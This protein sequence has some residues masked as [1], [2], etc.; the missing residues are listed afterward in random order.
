MLKLDK[1]NKKQYI[2]LNDKKNKKSIYKIIHG[3]KNMKIFTEEEII[4]MNNFSYDDRMSILLEY[5][6]MI[7]FLA[8]YY[9]VLTIE[10]LYS[11]FSNKIFFK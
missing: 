7:D 4:K 2:H 3:I 6:N 8:T 9:R 1:N 5:N 10:V 11:T